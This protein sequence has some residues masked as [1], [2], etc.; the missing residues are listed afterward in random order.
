MYR[1][2]YSQ[3]LVKERIQATVHELTEQGVINEQTLFL[4]MLNGGVWFASHF[5]DCIPDMMNEVHFIK[6]H[7]Y[8]G[9]S[10]GELI[11]DY[12]PKIDMHGRQVVVLDDICDSGNTTTAIYDALRPMTSNISF[13]TLLKR[14]TAQLKPEMT[15]YS[16]ITD[17]SD[18]FFVGC[19]LDD[20]ERGRMLPFVGIVEKKD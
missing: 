16:C 15:L 4:V 2:K 19:G 12:M 10:H 5:F 8:D 20:Y 7:S 11:W 14:T 18:D 9:T 17:D 3:A 1:I 13:V 6:G